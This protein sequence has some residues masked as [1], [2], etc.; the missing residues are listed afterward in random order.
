MQK[1]AGN[2]SVKLSTSVLN[3]KK[4]KLAQHISL[5]TIMSM[6]KGI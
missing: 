1:G 6:Q 5:N 4:F 2:F 3:P